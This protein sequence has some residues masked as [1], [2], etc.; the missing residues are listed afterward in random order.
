MIVG[1][2]Y[3]I[4]PDA[5]RGRISLAAS[6]AHHSAITGIE[7]LRL[8]CKLETGPLAA[9]SSASHDEVEKDF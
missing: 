6:L 4:P 8:K 9:A 7:F 2:F 1:W 3:Y 5:R